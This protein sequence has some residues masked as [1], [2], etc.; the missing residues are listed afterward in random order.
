MMNFVFDKEA[1][2]P[3]TEDDNIVA[4]NMALNVN[5]NILNVLIMF[6]LWICIQCFVSKAQRLTFARL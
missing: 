3:F 1:S 6:N 5:I 4:L 2:A